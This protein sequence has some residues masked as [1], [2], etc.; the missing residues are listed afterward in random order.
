MLTTCPLRLL[1]FSREGV[2]A[3]AA[4]LGTQGMTSD[5]MSITVESADPS[6][7]IDLRV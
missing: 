6:L 3:A 2:Y 1:D 4:A 5:V 7:R